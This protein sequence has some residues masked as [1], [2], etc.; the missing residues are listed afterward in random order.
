MHV[1]FYCPMSRTRKFFHKQPSV[2]NMSVTSVTDESMSEP[3]TTSVPQVRSSSQSS[4]INTCLNIGGHAMSQGLLR[5][6]QCEAIL[7]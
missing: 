2:D 1:C 7:F 6:N 3:T 5:I 4:V